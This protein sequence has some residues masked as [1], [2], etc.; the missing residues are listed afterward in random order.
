MT[1]IMVDEC[2]GAVK[3][4]KV[5]V[6]LDSEENRES[7]ALWVKGH[8]AW[9]KEEL[10]SLSRSSHQQILLDVVI[11]HWLTCLLK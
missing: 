6:I 1:D 11:H 7:K 3:W 2:F 4:L 9:S 8:V 10:S 5:Y